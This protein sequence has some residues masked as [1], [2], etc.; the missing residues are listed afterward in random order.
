M[1]GDNH[2]IEY[3]EAIG[4]SLVDIIFG[5]LSEKLG[6]FTYIL[7][8]VAIMV[9]GGIVASFS[10]VAGAIIILSGLGYI[11]YE[12]FFKETP[13]LKSKIVAVKNIS[14]NGGTPV[15]ASVPK[16]DDNCDAKAECSCYANQM[17]E[18]YTGDMISFDVDIEDNDKTTAYLTI[19]VSSVKNGIR[20]C[21]MTRTDDFELT[22]SGET[23]TIH[24]E[25]PVGDTEDKKGRGLPYSLRVQLKTEGHCVQQVKV[26]N[27]FTWMGSRKVEIVK[28]HD[29]VVNPQIGVQFNGHKEVIE[30][31]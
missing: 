25:V 4:K 9:A 12:L 21:V 5:S 13:T 8:G 14:V 29:L 10:K 23:K 19:I 27:A 15:Q 16:F 18:I 17:Q 26:C 28:I 11:I 1:C 20:H 30:W 31:V 22:G 2:T 3:N 24:V 7:I 6:E